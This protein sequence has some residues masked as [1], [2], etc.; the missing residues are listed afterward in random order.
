M[1]D[2]KIFLKWFVKICVVGLFFATRGWIVSF[3]AMSQWF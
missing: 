2:I 1:S 3:H